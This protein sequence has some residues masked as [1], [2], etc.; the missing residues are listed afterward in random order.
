M[1]KVPISSQVVRYA[2]LGRSPL[3]GR[4]SVNKPA[5]TERL[6]THNKRFLGTVGMVPLLNFCNCAI[7]CRV[8][9]A[10]KSQV[11]SWFYFRTPGFLGPIRFPYYSR[12]EIGR[13][14]KG[15]GGGISIFG[16]PIII[17][18]HQFSIFTKNQT[19]TTSI[20]S[21]ILRRPPTSRETN[22]ATYTHHAYTYSI[23]NYPRANAFLS[24]LNRS[25][26]SQKPP[27]PLAR[28]RRSRS[29]SSRYSPGLFGLN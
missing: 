4:R 26:A 9:R 20:A 8:L 16:K 3:P 21:V 6:D 7:F 13:T 19:S 25:A 14:F 17:E 11:F 5:V 1:P 10:F 12:G 18:N 29:C 2:R 24:A 15:D 27:L 23:S 28:T 22:H